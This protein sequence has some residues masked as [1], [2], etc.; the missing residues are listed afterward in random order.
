ML[1]E[2]QINTHTPFAL[3]TGSRKQ[4][5]FIATVDINKHQT[6]ELFVALSLLLRINQ[7]F[8]IQG[9]KVA[10]FLA[11]F[12]KI[13]QQLAQELLYLWQMMHFI[14]VRKALFL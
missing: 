7:S 1:F 14:Q 8:S 10:E 13:F 6:L 2:L 12:Q 9:R 5:D 11:F 3:I 4:S